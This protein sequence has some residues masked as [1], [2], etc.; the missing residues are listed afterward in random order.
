MSTRPTRAS[1]AEDLLEGDPTL[2]TS[3]R[4]P[5]AEVEP[6][7]E[8]EVRSLIPVDVEAV[9]FDEVALVRFAACR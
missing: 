7:A 2:E 1:A 9:G 5:Q 4:G 6:V 8:R 3:E